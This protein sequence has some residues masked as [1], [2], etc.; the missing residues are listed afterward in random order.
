[1]KDKWN[2]FFIQKTKVG[3]DYLNRKGIPTKSIY[4][5]YYNQVIRLLKKDFLETQKN[6]NNLVLKQNYVKN[7]IWVMWWQGLDQAP[8]LIKKNYQRIS[9]I[10]GKENVILIDK[11]NYKEFTNIKPELIEKLNNKK[12]TYTLWS[13]IVR[14][15]LLM[16]NG[17]LWIDSTVILSQKFDEYFQK[18]KQQKFF[19]LCNDKED[20]RYISNGKWTGWFIGGKRN[21]DLFKFV[22]CF[23]ETYFKNHSISIDYMLV[24]DAVSYYY[25]NNL[26]HRNIIEKQLQ[27]W[28]PYLFARNYK[29][30]DFNRI[31]DLFNKKRM[32]SVQKFTYKINTNEYI[33]TKALYYALNE[34]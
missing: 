12:I 4:V 31:F 8:Q 21:Y 22:T 18:I 11:S 20:Y 32:Y 15:N 23:F 2:K 28:D 27:Q 33:P 26:L 7:K 29:S 30:V 24:D 25:K 17:G 6:V 3:I 16:N 5:W 10:F 9:S 19:S 1:M 34:K 14:Y 13:D